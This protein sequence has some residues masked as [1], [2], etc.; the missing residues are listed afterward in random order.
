MKKILDIRF[1]FLP[2]LL[3]MVALFPAC[4]KNNENGA[5]PIVTSVRL[6]NPS[7]KDS[8][9]ST[10]SPTDPLLSGGAGRYVVI[11]GKNLQNATEI[12]FDG[13]AAT[14]NTAL[15]APNSAVVQI[16]NIVFS[17]I[18]TTKLYT[19]NYKTPGGSTTFSFK[20]GAPAPT[21]SAISNVF[22][23][24]GDSVYLYGANLVLVQNFVY[25]GTKI[26]SFQ[27]SVD[28]ST[29]GFLMP[30]STST[31]L[32]NVTT[33]FGT[34]I[35]TIKAT[36]TITGIS[37]EDA[38][39]GDSVYIYG[40]Y[41][42]SISAVSY[43]G[44]SIDP[45]TLKMSKDLKSIGFVVPAL[46]QAGP[47]SV[48][49]VFGTAT[50]VYNVNDYATNIIGNMEWDINSAFFGYGWNGG[51][52]YV[53][54]PPGDWRGYN[55]LFSGGI[56]TNGSYNHSEYSTMFAE[57]QNDIVK[58][59]DDGGN[60]YWSTEQWVPKANL[61][62]D[63]SSWALKFEINVPANWNGGTLVI[64]TNVSNSPYVARWEPWRQTG[65]AYKTKAWM[66]VTVPLS[67]FRATDATLG[68][69]MGKPLAQII[70]LIG[71]T[72]SIDMHTYIHNYDSSNTAT[73]FLGGFDNL[74]VVK[75]K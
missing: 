28:G 45:S 3:A 39:A 51:S 1:Y 63:P 38:I 54:F 74:R 36:P 18:D 5:A 32:I 6:Y 65:H 47:V 12:D 50:T 13:V 58:P 9:L 67:A 4:K 48:T 53:C 21:I 24:P 35:D 64:K 46:S 70:D 40:T 17:T 22:A 42:K 14:F 29:L 16:P 7:P 73:G 10:G 33:K 19:I 71:T 66:T 11:I 8:L 20:L 69:G 31:R 61:G 25:G 41:F 62:D 27:S 56:T 26:S 60:I 52:L 49:T 30:A 23:N 34:A 15:F 2:L 59:G 44:V 72:G 75:I 37:D 68:E 55:P 57:M 43:A